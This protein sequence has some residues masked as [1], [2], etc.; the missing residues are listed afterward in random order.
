MVKKLDVILSPLLIDNFTFENKTTVVIDI[1]RATTTIC[2]ALQNGASFVY[3]VETLEEASRLKQNGY[4]AAAERDGTR[5]DGFDLG[6][7]PA[8]YRPDR[9][10]NQSIVLTTTNGTRCIRLSESS[11]QILVGAFS[12]ISTLANFLRNDDKDL[13]LFCAGWKNKVNLE[14][15]L[16]AGALADRLQ[17]DYQWDDDAVEV[18]IDLY[19]GAQKNLLKYVSKAA[20]A[21]RFEKMGVSTD[22]AY[23]LQEDT[24][25]VLPVLRDNKLVNI[26]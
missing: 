5:V 13:L 18:A 25:D 11:D 23:C 1:L 3:P 16:F 14:D 7:S 10:A 20:H 26:H 4:M 8:E 9:V 17:G 21:R 12:N 24:C 15:T 6:N 19:K 2:T 22:T